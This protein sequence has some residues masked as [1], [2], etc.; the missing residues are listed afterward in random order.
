MK[1]PSASVQARTNRVSSV[2]GT[3]TAR[4]TTPQILARWCSTA[5]DLNSDV[6]IQ[7][8]LAARSASSSISGRDQQPIVEWQTVQYCFRRGKLRV[9]MIALTATDGRDC[10]RGFDG[11][12]RATL[13]GAILCTATGWAAEPPRPI[14]DFPSYNPSAYCAAPTRC[15]RSARAP[16]ILASAG[17]SRPRAGSGCRRSGRASRRS[18]RPTA[19][20]R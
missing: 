10:P 16:N 20:P 13:L 14:D 15:L 5:S 8:P 12:L 1:T 9:P 19:R 6:V 11:G 4:V 3:G 2:S 7:E 18:P 17:R